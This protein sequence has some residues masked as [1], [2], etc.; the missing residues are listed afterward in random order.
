M[1][2]F[3][4]YMVISLAISASVSVFTKLSIPDSLLSTLYSVA[5]IVFSV[6]MCIAISPKTEEV[7]NMKMKQSI[8]QSYIK[9]RNTFIIFFAIDTILFVLASIDLLMKIHEF[10]SLLCTIFILFSLA[11][12]VYNFIALQKLGCDVEDQV[13]KEKMNE[14]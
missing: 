12:F 4:A 9:V 8:R 10:V 2:K 5:G 14:K 11:Y 6:G 3:A 1:K 13:L 7:T